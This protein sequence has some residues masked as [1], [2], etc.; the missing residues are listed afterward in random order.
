[1]SMDRQPFPRGR[2]SRADA[3]CMRASCPSHNSS[4]P[5][6]QR[7]AAKGHN[8][9]LPLTLCRRCGR[10]GAVGTLHSLVT[11]DDLP[12]L[13]DCGTFL[14]RE[15]ATEPSGASSPSS[16]VLERGDNFLMGTLPMRRV[17]RH[18]EDVGRFF[19]QD[20]SL[21]PQAA[22]ARRGYELYAR[23]CPTA[24]GSSHER[25]KELLAGRVLSGRA[26]VWFRG[27]PGEDAEHGGAGMAKLKE[28]LRNWEPK[29]NVTE[30]LGLE[31]QRE[32]WE[33]AAPMRSGVEARRR[34]EEEEKD[35]T[36]GLGKELG[37]GGVRGETWKPKVMGLGGGK[38]SRRSEERARLVAEERMKLGAVVA[39]AAKGE[40]GWGRGLEQGTKRE[41]EEGGHGGLQDNMME[42]SPDGDDELAAKLRARKKVWDMQ[43]RKY[44][45]EQDLNPGQARELK[46]KR[47][48][49]GERIRKNT[50][51][52]E[53]GAGAGGGAYKRWTS[54]SGLRVQGEGEVESA[55]IVDKVR[56]IRTVETITLCI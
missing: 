11:A 51:G 53:G 48:E 19:D 32:L 17:T 3:A 44:V 37:L 28:A 4:A 38:R 54:S 46:I 10:A 39:E 56:A 50:K 34:E 27:L 41:R 23:T 7:G 52:G 2:A 33:V 55:K 15:I 30:S 22:T 12:H 29:G 14:G 18:L 26:H 42:V 9:C 45:Y 40:D 31:W 6:R 20:G 25:S 35:P 21:A 36:G 1:M 16:T 5:R 8:L 13:V 43:K 47:N 24:S 49:A